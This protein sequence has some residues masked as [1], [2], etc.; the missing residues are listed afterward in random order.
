MR[1]HLILIIHILETLESR[2][3]GLVFWGVEEQ[4]FSSYALD[5]SAFQILKNIF[6]SYSS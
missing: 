6:F 1:Y 4:F 3:V 5:L 2:I